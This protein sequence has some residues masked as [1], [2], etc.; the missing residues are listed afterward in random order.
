MSVRGGRLLI[1]RQDEEGLLGPSFAA[2]SLHFEGSA[3]FDH[4]C[5]VLRGLGNA[6]AHSELRAMVYVAKI[7]VALRM[8]A[9]EMGWAH[10]E[11]TILLGDTKAALEGSLLDKMKRQ[12]RFLAA[13]EAMLRLWVR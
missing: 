12:G 6:T 3:P 7:A 10:E 9:R 5:M 13:Q 4:G 1:R 8:L 11:P 2:W